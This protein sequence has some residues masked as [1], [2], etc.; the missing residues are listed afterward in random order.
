MIRRKTKKLNNQGSTFVL[1]L[2]I[3]TFITTLALA[4]MSASLNN[5]AMKNVDRN[6]TS[7]FYTSESVLDEL[8]AGVG[9]NAMNVLGDAYEAVLTNI[10]KQDASGYA[11]LMDNDAAKLAFKDAFVSKMLSNVSAGML[12]FSGDSKEMSNQDP[13][14]MTTVAA[15]L[16]SYIKGYDAG[17]AGIESVGGVKAYKNSGSG[18]EHTLIIKDVVISYKEQKSG[19]TYFSYVTAD[20]EIEFPNMSIDFSSSNRLDDFTGYALIADNSMNVEGGV[21]NISGSVYA[22]QNINVLPDATKGGEL[23]VSAF[24]SDKINVICGGNVDGGNIVASGNADYLSSIKFSNANIWCTNLLTNRFLQGG[25]D[26]TSGAVIEIDSLCSTFV[27]DDLTAEGANSKITLDGEYYGYSYDGYDADSIHANSSAV[28]INGTGTNLT[29]GTRKMILGGHAFVQVTGDDGDYMTGESLSFKGDQEIYLVPSEYLAKNYGDAVT[30][31]MSRETWDLLEEAA[32]DDPNVKICDVTGF[33]AQTQGYLA[34]VPYTVRKA[35][36]NIVYV[37]FNFKDKASAAEYIKDVANGRNGADAEL[38]ARLDRYTESLFGGDNSVKIEGDGVSIYTKGALLV[39]S[40]GRTASTVDGITNSVVD[41]V[42][43]A[44]S[45]VGVSNDDFVLTAMD[46]KNRYSILTHLLADIPWID[47]ANGGS[48][49]IVNDIDSALWQKKD[50]LISG[51][52]MSTNNIFDVIID[53]SWLDVHE[54]NTTGAAI[55]YGEGL[56]GNYYTKMAIKGNYTVPAQCIGGIIIATGSVTLDHDFTGMIIAGDNI[57]VNGYAN[58]KSDSVLVKYFI[59]NELGF[60]DES[61]EVDIEFRDYFNAFKRSAVDPDSREEVKVETVDYKDL[62][63][64]N[65]WRKY[66]D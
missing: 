5:I 23:I 16:N 43:Y 13:A 28:I 14:I 33:F 32:N 57:L 7:T 44:N 9:L 2:I 6:A 15:Y 39:T 29:I 41:G 36:G 48:R 18:L 66:E 35:A 11:Y 53:R 46:L 60:A 17:M 55:Q 65:N 58:I 40:D 37:Y 47:A 22:G 45:G 59:E 61:I 63:N 34:D 51:N 4:V 64:F 12:S 21:A 10:I 20:L 38:T 49:Y 30:N 31:P 1:A 8:R 54:Y 19:E 42:S 62:V 3:I 52:E 27:K 25:S 24:G 50:Y 26:K 56:G